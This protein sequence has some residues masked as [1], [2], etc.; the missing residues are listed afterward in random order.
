ME[1]GS[2]RGRGRDHGKQEKIGVKHP[3]Y[4]VLDEIR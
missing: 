3:M 1:P 4:Q 2:V